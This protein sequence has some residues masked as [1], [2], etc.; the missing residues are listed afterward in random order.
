MRF[1][2]ELSWMISVPNGELHI[3]YL[4][5]GRCYIYWIRACPDQAGIE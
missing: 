2:P 5:K 1:C 3:L 4:T